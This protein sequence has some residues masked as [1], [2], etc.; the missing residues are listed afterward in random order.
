MAHVPGLISRITKVFDT[1]PAI[2]E[3]TLKDQFEKLILQPFLE[4]KQ[5]P[6]KGLGLIIV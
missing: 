2:S 1:D 5:A 3:K 4:I 6:P